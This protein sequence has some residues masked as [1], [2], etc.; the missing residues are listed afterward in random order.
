MILHSTDQSLLATS[1]AIFTSRHSLNLFL[2]KR[3]VSISLRLLALTVI[4]AFWVR[5]GYVEGGEG[6]EQF[7]GRDVVAPGSRAVHLQP[8][9]VVEALGVDQKV[10]A[11]IVAGGQ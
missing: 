2:R 7:V 11:E 6:P 5:R 1:L 4:V 8:A 9:V 10:L 3:R